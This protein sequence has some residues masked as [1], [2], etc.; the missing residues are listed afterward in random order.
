[1]K[2]LILSLALFTVSAYSAQ[3]PMFQSETTDGKNFS[4]KDRLKD[5]KP[6]LVSFWA[7]WCQPCL[8]ELNT[9][10][11]KLGKNA[12]VDVVAVNVDTSE[13][14][15]DVRPTARLH[16]IEFPIILDPKHQIFSK[17]NSTK[18]VPY[19]VLVSAT[20]EILATYSGYSEEMMQKLESFKKN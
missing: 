14:S 13:T 5:G 15:S 20:G 17:F 8:D 7:T 4:L 6:V 16:K 1:M 18:A 10:K 19:S 3:A 9:L 11:A 12:G 2:T